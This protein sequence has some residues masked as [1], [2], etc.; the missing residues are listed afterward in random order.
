MVS[1]ASTELPK[2][3]VILGQELALKYQQNESGQ[4][5]AEYISDGQ[6]LENW[7]LM[8]AI[9]SY[10]GNNLDA[11]ASVLATAQN[12]KKRK[13]NG[14]TV[15]NY[16]IFKSDDGSYAIDFLDSDNKAV[17]EHNIFKYIKTDDG[18]VSLQVARRL[19]L[20]NKTEKQIKQFFQDIPVI[21]NRVLKEL[22]SQVIPRE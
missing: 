13:E 2:S 9:R 11:K 15:A 16:A 18:L 14:D 6:T 3:V 4:S 22:A 8:Y 21:R 7:K 17:F 10:K 5:L 20:K 1:A 19:Y 12:I